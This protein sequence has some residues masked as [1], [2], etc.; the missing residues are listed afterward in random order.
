HPWPAIPA[1][2]RPPS[3]D[4]NS[5]SRYTPPQSPADALQ[6]PP[7]AT[8]SR[9]TSPAHPPSGASPLSAHTAPVPA[10]HPPATS[11]AAPPPPADEM[12]QTGSTTTARSPQTTHPAR[13][14]APESPH[15]AALS[16]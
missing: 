16:A 3:I 13:S 14:S 10:S 9:R 4:T 15:T 2:T 8:R 12:L 5:P 7:A 11:S 1:A 6:T